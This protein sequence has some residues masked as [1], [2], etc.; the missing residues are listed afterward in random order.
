MAGSSSSSVLVERSCQ[1]LREGQGATF[2]FTS[3]C[4]GGGDV[5][6]AATEDVPVCWICLDPASSHRPLTL[7]CNCP[8][9]CHQVCLARW[10]LQS[11]GTR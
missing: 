10:Q 5:V 4:T 1:K 8:R 6:E 9:Y 7:P 3:D 2:S 11:A